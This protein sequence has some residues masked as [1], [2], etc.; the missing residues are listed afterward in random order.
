MSF[1]ANTR[2]RIIQLAQQAKPAGGGIVNFQLPR[3]GFLARIYLAIRG[4]ITGTLTAPNPL[5]RASI[6]RRVRLTANSGVDTFNV[7]GAGYHYLLR[8]YVDL[9]RDAVPQS[10]ALTAVGTGAFNLDMVIP[11]G[12]NKRDAVGLLMLQSER[13]LMTLQVDFEADATVATGA[14]VSATVTPYLELFTVPADQAN[15]PPLSVVHQILEDQQSVPAAGTFTYHWPRGHVYLQLLHG[16]GIGIPGSDLF[17]RVNVR[18][19]QADFIQATDV[20]YLDIERAFSAGTTRLAGTIPIDLMGSSGMGMYDKSRDTI[21]TRLVTD[22]ATV[23]EATAS[24]TL[25][26]VRRQLV[27]LEG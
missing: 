11:V 15:W 27:T 12:V 10:N 9:E 3:T 5:G 19:N 18:V 6:V 20:V 21:N 14:T 17:T 25:Y 24:G 16:L 22:L 7:S 2:R 26:S 1:D 23:I 8:E 13:T 4:S